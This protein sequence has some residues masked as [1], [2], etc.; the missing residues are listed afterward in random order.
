MPHSTLSPEAVQLVKLVSFLAHLQLLCECCVPQVLALDPKKR[1][2]NSLVL[3]DC[4]ICA[5]SQIFVLSLLLMFSVSSSPPPSAHTH[6]LPPSVCS[7]CTSARRRFA[8][9][10]SALCVLCAVW[11]ACSVCTVL[12]CTRALC[13]CARTHAVCAEYRR[14]GQCTS[15]KCASSGTASASNNSYCRCAG[16]SD[17]MA[18]RNVFTHAQEKA[19][20]ESAADVAEFVAKRARKDE[21]T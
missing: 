7:R 21:S 19:A 13:L 1:S 14:S 20:R 9:R 8:C 2:V 4:G 6:S 10:Q 11:C 5:N 15:T 3:C 12:C 18:L 17:V 16:V